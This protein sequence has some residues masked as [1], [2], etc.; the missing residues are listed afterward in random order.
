MPFNGSGTFTR[1]M[2]WVGDAAANI[3]IRADRHDQEDDNFAAGLSKCICSDGQSIVTGDI[4]FNGHKLVNVGNPV[5]AQDV[6]TRGFLDGFGGWSTAKFISGADENGRLNFTSLTGANGITWS[7]IGASW[8]ARIGVTDRQRNRVVLN[9]N[10]D[11]SGTDVIAIDEADG[12]MAFPSYMHAGTNLYLDQAGSW[13]TPAA[14]VGSLLR[15]GAGQLLLWGNSVATTLANGVAA[16][17]NWFGLTYSGGNIDLALNKKA[18]GNQVALHGDTAGVMRWLL[19]LGN[20]GAENAANDGSDFSLSCYNQAGG[21]IQ[22]AMIGYR[23]TG[24][25]SF[26]AGITGVLTVDNWINNATGAVVLGGTAG[27]YLRP[28]GANVN[29]APQTVIQTTGDITCSRY[30]DAW[31]IW[32][33]AGSSGSKGT[34]VFNFLYNTST[35]IRAYVGTTFVGTWTPVCDYRIK[36]EVQPLPSCWEA[37]KA[38]R[39]VK[40]TDKAYGDGQLFK[41]GADERWGFLAHELQEALLPSA[42]TGEKDGADLQVPNHITVIAALTSALQEAMRRIEALEARP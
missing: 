6:V 16:L 37:V 36:R 3:K 31:G 7:N 10:V 25:V 2:N 28:T 39:P 4:G 12:I 30:L 9:N 27:V 1:V 15:W 32:E 13:R 5:D 21:Y 40:Y 38:L 41:D 26:P 33:R 24:K 20:S 29:G 35:D 34:Q 23:K 42:A 8:L 11:G 14:G 17:E 18:S 22:T 19:L